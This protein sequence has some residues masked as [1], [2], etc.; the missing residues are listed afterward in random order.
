[1]KKR[2]FLNDAICSL[3]FV[4]TALTVTGC[5][6]GPQEVDQNYVKQSTDNAKLARSIFDANQGK[7]DAVS[8]DDK[9]KL[10][11]AY[12]SETAAKKV[13]DTMANPPMGGGPPASAGAPLPTGN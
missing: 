9:K 3:V 6:A 7:W 4:F 2:H 12:G 11:D 1:M 8:P 5:G 13:W 10:S